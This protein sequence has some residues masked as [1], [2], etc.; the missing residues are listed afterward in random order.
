MKLNIQKK[1]AAKAFKGAEKRVKFNPEKLAD[2]KE[3]I[4]KADIKI[5]NCERTGDGRCLT[6]S[7][8]L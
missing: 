6:R 2:I 3:A 1:L 7:L 4:T 5:L 8:I